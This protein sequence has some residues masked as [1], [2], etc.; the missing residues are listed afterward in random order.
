M[1]YSTVFSERSLE[2]FRALL[3]EPDE[4]SE[5]FEALAADADEA[6]TDRPA[7]RVVRVVRRSHR[8]HPWS[9]DPAADSPHGSAH[10]ER[11]M[12]EAVVH[13]YNPAQLRVLGRVQ[14]LLAQEG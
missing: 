7:E 14:G 9:Q 8:E 12:A 5:G 1:V 3:G 4:T 10:A 13:L 6:T 2:G 11:A